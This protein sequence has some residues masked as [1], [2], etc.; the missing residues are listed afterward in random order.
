VLIGCGVEREEKTAVTVFEKARCALVCQAL[1]RA[2][3]EVA[4][5]DIRQT[6][7]ESSPRH[8][9]YPPT[10]LPSAGPT[11]QV[12]PEAWKPFWPFL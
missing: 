4:E 11:V 5:V 7:F 12:C 9:L 8:E 3:H 1:E 6:H 10:D 2:L